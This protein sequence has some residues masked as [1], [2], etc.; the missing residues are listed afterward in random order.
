MIGLV[1]VPKNKAGLVYKKGFGGTTNRKVSLS[2]SVGYQA[3]LL[4]EGIHYG[5]SKLIY[6]IKFIDPIIIGHNE[7]ALVIA[8]DGK[9]ING[10]IPL[11]KIVEC[12][13]FQ[14][15][16]AFIEK[17]GE[18]G[19]QLGILTQGEYFINPQLFQVITKENALHFEYT[20]EWLNHIFVKHDEIALV[21][22]KHGT[23]INGSIG[24]GKIVECNNFQNPQEFIDNGGER[25]K[26]LHILK[27]GKYYINPLLFQVITHKNAMDNGLFPAM[28][29][30]YKIDKKMVG[31][32]SVLVG[33]EN[34]L[35]EISKVDKNLHNSYQN[36]QDFFDN[37]GYK[38][39]QE[40]VITFGEYAINPWFAEIRQ[41]AITKIPTGTVGVV[42]SHTGEEPE[43]GEIV[44]EEHRG[45]WSHPLKVGKHAINTETKTIRL[46]PTNEI[47]L[48]WAEKKEKGSDNYDKD[49]DLIKL[50]TK[51]GYSLG[52]EVIQ[53]IQIQEKDAPKLISQI[54]ENEIG[55]VNQE[56]VQK[57]YP[58]I[59]NLINRKIQGQIEAYFTST[60]QGYN[61]IE[62]RNNLDEIQ[63]LALEMIRSELNKYGVEATGLSIIIKDF[64][65]IIEENLRKMA[66]HKHN[67]L[68]VI[69]QTEI[70]TLIQMGKSKIDELGAMS[71]S[72]VK[73]ITEMTDIELWEMRQE[74]EIKGAKL[75]AELEVLKETAIIEAYGK[76]N[77]LEMKRMEA[78]AKVK[79]PEYSRMDMSEFLLTEF[80]SS[81]NTNCSLNNEEQVLEK[82]EKLLNNPKEK[83]NDEP[84]PQK[85]IEK[86]EFSVFTQDKIEKNKFNID[87]W[88]YL[89]QQYNK[90]EEHI[91]RLSRENLV[92]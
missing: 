13:N 85:N 3:D 37:G 42:V 25:G 7:I 74:S 76:E 9:K 64:P 23:D 47:S 62:F 2:N 21:I 84:L 60:A 54:A 30:K 16:R 78:L 46:I 12:D 71:Q 61:A 39:L 91:K 75:Y 69:Q 43:E 6:D 44:G 49:L 90:V 87:V 57:K 77:Y 63:N 24:V 1:N 72:N 81:K 34:D 67:T 66:E 8:K 36:P 5:L 10:D 31:I 88:A 41:I 92:G 22:S 52:L 4:Y 51:D 29:K 83:K 59:R 73:K 20:P 70:D 27:E 35:N 38:G 55:E 79:F 48:K 32:V 11:G 33:S 28:L 19:Q 68:N 86:V 53:T 80:Y 45:I 26:Q 65:K 18:K 14:N 89:S 50:G 56:K 82:I 40:E 58:A 17:G 15:A